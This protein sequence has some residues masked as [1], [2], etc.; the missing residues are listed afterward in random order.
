[1]NSYSNLTPIN[2]DVWSKRKIVT[3]I[4][5]TSSKCKAQEHN[6]KIKREEKQTHQEIFT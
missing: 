2:L 5:V 3:V 6:Q 1:V 4:K